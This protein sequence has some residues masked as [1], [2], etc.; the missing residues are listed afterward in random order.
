M[1]HTRHP[2]SD[3]RRNRLQSGYEAGQKACGVAILFVQRQPGGRSLAAGDPF[4]EQPGFAEAGGGTDE[5]QFAV[6]NLVQPLDQA[7]A[8]D[9]FRTRRGNVKFSG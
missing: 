1:E 8:V 7:G 3:I 6:R 9:G 5:G 2:F 4:A